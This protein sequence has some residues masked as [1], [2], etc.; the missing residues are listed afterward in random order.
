MITESSALNC[1]QTHSVIFGTF[2]LVLLVLLL[3][4]YGLFYGYVHF[5]FFYTPIY[6]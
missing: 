2:F 4:S 3:R 6:F 5:I 1:E